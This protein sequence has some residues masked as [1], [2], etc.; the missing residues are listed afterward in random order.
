MRSN[1][2]DDDDDDE[3]PK[4]H[5]AQLTNALRSEVALLTSLQTSPLPKHA[6]ASTLWAQRLWLMRTFFAQVCNS[7][8][9]ESGGQSGSSARG[10][11]LWDRELGV[12]MRAGER[13]ARNYYAWEYA[14]QVFRLV[15]GELA[16]GQWI[17]GG[18]Q[19]MVVESLGRVHAWCLMHPRDV[20][21][22][23]CLVFL[24]ARLGEFVGRGDSD[25]DGGIGWYESEVGRIEGETKGFVRKYE[26]RGESLAWF[27]KSVNQLGISR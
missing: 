12:V 19:A 7:M 17:G 8:P 26:W 24:L 22:W 27:L 3:Q 4:H 21:G 11:R 13:H 25:I 14:R 6:K 23:G 16:Q 9:G 2:N 18:V 10:R 20:S 5:V 1:D 15:T